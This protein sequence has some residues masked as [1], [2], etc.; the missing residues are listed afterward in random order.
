[1]H[2]TGTRPTVKPQLNACCL[3]Y[4]PCQVLASM[5]SEVSAVVD[6]LAREMVEVKGEVIEIQG[7]VGSLDTR[8]TLLEI[9]LKNEEVHGG[10]KG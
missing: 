2:S 8:V 7:H 3:P 4:F 5:L 6:R 9:R 1:M 10:G